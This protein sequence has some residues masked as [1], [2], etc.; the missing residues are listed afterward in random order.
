MRFRAFRA[1]LVNESTSRMEKFLFSFPARCRSSSKNIIEVLLAHL[2]PAAARVQHTAVWAA[3]AAVAGCTVLLYALD[4]KGGKIT[5]F[6]RPVR[7]GVSLRFAFLAQAST[8][9][10]RALVLHVCA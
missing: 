2:R 9:R 6:S 10:S 8:W 3:L 7:A 5:F 1:L 4:E